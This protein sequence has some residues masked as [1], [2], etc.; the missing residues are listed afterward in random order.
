MDAETIFRLLNAAFAKETQPVR[1]AIGE[2][3]G[4]LVF[5]GTPQQV[6]EAR[7][8]LSKLGQ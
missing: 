6:E 2:K 7:R 5:E 1:F 3:T 8:I 4:G